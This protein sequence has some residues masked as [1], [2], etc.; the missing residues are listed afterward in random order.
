M[1]ER[2]SEFDASAIGAALTELAGQVKTAYKNNDSELYASTLDEDAIISMPGAPP[3]RG[4]A[5]LKA[6][7]ESRPPLP[8]G[9]TFE[10]EPR[11]LE[12]ISGDWAYAFGTDTLTIPLGADDAPV[13]QT[14]TFMVL[15]RRTPEGWK[16]FREVISTDQ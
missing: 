4:R 5:A 12:I 1:H 11:E 2:E 6:A 16:T 13:V 9:A 14:M 8:P 3:I 15:I 7:F 10:V